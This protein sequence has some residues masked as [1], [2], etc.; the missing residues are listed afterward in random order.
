[1]IQDGGNI[2]WATCVQ[3]TLSV[4]VI[5]QE[6][7]VYFHALVLLKSILRGLHLV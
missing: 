3:V 1:M 7:A 4:R 5:N 2:G 6:K